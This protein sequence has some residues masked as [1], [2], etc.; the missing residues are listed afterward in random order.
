MRDNK[1][2]WL[3][4]EISNLEKERRYFKNYT[5]M[6]NTIMFKFLLLLVPLLFMMSEIYSSCDKTVNFSDQAKSASWVCKAC[7]KYNYSEKSDWAGRHQC[8]CGQYKD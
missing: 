3:F 4:S 6:D 7:G 5:L 1:E 8:P 2:N